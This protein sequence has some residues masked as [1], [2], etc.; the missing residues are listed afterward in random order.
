MRIAV[1]ARFAVLDERG[2]GRYTRAVIAELRALPG[3]SLSYVVPGLFAPRAR[4]ASALGVPK[5]D[6][7]TRVPNDA[8]L[9]WG[10]SNG[11]DL[12][13]SLPYVTTVHDVVPFV[14]PAADPGARKREEA[15]L[16]RTAERARCIVADSDFM[17]AEIAAHLHVAR[18]RI[19]AVPLGVSSAF[20]TRGSRHALAGGRPYVLHVGAHDARKNTGTLI[21]AW[22]RAFP[23]ASV[24][25]AFTRAPQTLPPGALVVDAPHDAD[26][27]ALYRGAAAVAVP[28]LDE[29]FGLPLLEALA[30]GAPAI[31]SRVAALPEVGGDAVALDSTSPQNADDV[32]GGA[33]RV[34]RPRSGCRGGGARRT[35]TRAGGDVYMGA[36]A[37]SSRSPRFA[38]RRRPH[39]AS[40]LRPSGASRP[41][42]V[43]S[44][45]RCDAG[46]RRA[47]SSI[48][49]CGSSSA[50]RIGSA[51]AA[52]ICRAR[53]RFCI[54]STRTIFPITSW[55]RRRT[56]SGC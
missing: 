21:A 25:L 35:R 28:S 42:A 17:A 52:R 38:P 51:T 46:V 44:F 19:A 49:A 37:R 39:D 26:L 48:S 13:T 33:A 40:S 55:R 2:I 16:L 20:G 31:A 22:Q 56:I 5:S 15:Q 45:S 29:G 43:R 1:D 10:P 6:V 24:A 30:C 11:S 7:R 41:F 47:L 32:D 53:C 14:F 4:I 9:V 34:S 3:V 50:L 18:E 23:D 12:A 54:I 27:A 36:H 8:T